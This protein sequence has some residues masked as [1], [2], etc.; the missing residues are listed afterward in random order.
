MIASLLHARRA[1]AVPACLLV[2]ALAGVAVAPARA[3]PRRR[4]HRV[5]LQAFL[6]SSAPDSLLDLKAHASSIHVVYPT[7]FNCEIPSGQIVGADIPAVTDYA[8]ARAIVVMPRFNCQDGATVH[9]ILT[10]PQT[11]SATLARLAAIA[12][13]PLYGGLN[14]D[15]E[16]DGAEDREA[17]S[18]FVAALARNLHAHRKK[19]SV[20]V[21][22]FMG[23]GA[24]VANGFY[25]Y[26]ALSG[27]ADSVFVLAWG[28]H[29]A[30]ST[31]GPIAALAD[32]EAAARYIAS[33][34]NASRFVLGAPMYGLDWSEG[35]PAS[36]ATAY[37]FSGI[38]A[39]ARSVGAVPSRDGASQE[40]TFTYTAVGVT[41]RV[42]YLD[43]R[44]VLALLRIGRAHGLSVGIWRLGAEDQRLWSSSLLAG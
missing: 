21:D 38:V 36:L 25:D 37:E 3:S 1:R 18:T 30:G 35:A 9:Q 2:L 20:V 6:L 16:N 12:R 8:R 32:A 33:L 26:R 39:L 4:G 11:R 40:M 13:D 34:P 42:W 7:Y 24:T 19:L 27:A 28:A 44:A 15:L 43:A 22:G 14:L 10:D 5:A 17:L 29:W 31:P 23:E 41:H